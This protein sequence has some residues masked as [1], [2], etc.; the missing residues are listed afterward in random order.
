MSVGERHIMA[1]KNQQFNDK[2][3]CQFGG[4]KTAIEPTSNLSLR[5]F[6]VPDI[7]KVESMRVR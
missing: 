4:T 7:Q 3:S 5:T 6:Y 2:R 1:E